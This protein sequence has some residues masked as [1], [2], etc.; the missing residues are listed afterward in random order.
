MTVAAS[1]DVATRVRITVKE[2]LP[3]IADVLV[4]V[5]PHYGRPSSSA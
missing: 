5:E 2:S 1:H 3:W 4:H